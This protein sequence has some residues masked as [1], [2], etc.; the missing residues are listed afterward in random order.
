MAL[1]RNIM[2]LALLVELK[3][4]IQALAVVFVSVRSAGLLKE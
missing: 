2:H 3:N 4:N 1:T